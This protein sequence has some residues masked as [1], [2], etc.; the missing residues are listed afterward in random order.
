MHLRSN[1]AGINI[2]SVLDTTN[3]RWNTFW[4]ADVAVETGTEDQLAA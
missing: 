2:V 3:N 4:I 1:T